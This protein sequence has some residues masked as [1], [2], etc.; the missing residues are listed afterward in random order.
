MAR[1][2]KKIQIEKVVSEYHFCVCLGTDIH[3]HEWVNG[4]WCMVYGSRQMV[5][6]LLIAMAIALILSIT[7][8]IALI[9]SST[10]SIAV[11]LVLISSLH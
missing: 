5:V 10:T 8:S 3:F 2:N 6:S 7:I 4:V 1:D 11:L 9:S